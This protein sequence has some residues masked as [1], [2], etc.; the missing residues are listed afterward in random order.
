MYQPRPNLEPHEPAVEY[1]CSCDECEVCWARREWADWVSRDK[2]AAAEF[3][4]WEEWA[5]V[6]FGTDCFVEVD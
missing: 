2:S 1:D 6:V 5:D 4:Y 3:D